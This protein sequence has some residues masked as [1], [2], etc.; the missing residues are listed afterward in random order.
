MDRFGL[1][2]LRNL[3]EMHSEVSLTV[4]DLDDMAENC[5]NLER[6]A[7]NVAV[8][9]DILPFI[10]KARNLN[11]VKVQKFVRLLDSEIKKFHKNIIFPK[12][13]VLEEST[14]KEQKVINLSFLNAERA[15]LPNAQA[16]TL[17]V[18]EEVYLATKWAMKQTD[19]DFIKLRRIQ[20]Y[21]CDNGFQF[22][23]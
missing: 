13:E 11:K 9:D 7:F 23:S 17:Y 22:M 5:K 2:Q 21:Y 4:N 19:F 12:D 14:C 6:V 18:K 1:S 20:S 16:I 3:E 10:K 15:K 8:F